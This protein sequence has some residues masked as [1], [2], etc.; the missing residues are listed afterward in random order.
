MV[1]S[2]DCT[3]FVSSAGMFTT[4]FLLPVDSAQVRK[5]FTLFALDVKI[6]MTDPDIKFVALI[7]TVL[8]QCPLLSP[9]IDICSL[10]MLTILFWIES[11]CTNCPS[12]DN[13]MDVWIVFQ[14]VLLV[15]A[16]VDG[17]DSAQAIGQEVMVNE[18]ID[19]KDQLMN[20][21]LVRQRALKL[22]GSTGIIAALC[23][24][25]FITEMLE[26]VKIG[27]RIFRQKNP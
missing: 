17:S 10:V 8:H 6:L 9:Y 11:I 21:Q 5:R 4:Q 12:R 27:W 23:S 22:T 14:W 26:I 13:N 19:N 3:F 7:S 24:L 15:F 2:F 16:L 20:R 25:N 18:F 1:A